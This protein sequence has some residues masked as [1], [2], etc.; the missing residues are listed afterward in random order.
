[1][2]VSQT[3]SRGAAIAGFTM[4]MGLG[5]ASAQIAEPLTGDPAMAS[6]APVE[7][8]DAGSAVS[9]SISFDFNSH[10]ISYG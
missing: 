2:K 6:S 1:M 8:V 9:G 3:K 4:L 7:E 10:F 5:T